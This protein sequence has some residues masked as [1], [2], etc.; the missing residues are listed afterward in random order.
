MSVCECNKKK[1]E[2]NQNAKTNMQPIRK[3]DDCSCVGGNERKRRDR[4]KPSLGQGF[5]QIH[6]SRLQDHRSHHFNSPMKGMAAFMWRVPHT[7]IAPKSPD[8]TKMRLEAD[9]ETTLC[10]DCDLPEY[11][12]ESR[13]RVR[14]GCWN[15]PLGSSGNPR[16]KYTFTPIHKTLT[17]TSLLSLVRN[18]V[19]TSP[20]DHKPL[21]EESSS[22]GSIELV[23]VGG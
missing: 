4:H 23:N 2:R 16:L 11:R 5:N 12:S 17:H 19:A 8:G 6:T 22:L 14:R 18:R 13:A 3:G 9:Q 21:H 20:A 1:K 15:N 7:V 10:I